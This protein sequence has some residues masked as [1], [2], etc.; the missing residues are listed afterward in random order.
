MIILILAQNGATQTH[1]GWSIG[2]QDVAAFKFRLCRPD[3]K[4]SGSIRKGA[5][6]AGP[7]NGKRNTHTHALAA[8]VRSGA[9]R[10]DGG[11]GAERFI[12]ERASFGAPIHVSEI[13]E[14]A[15]RRQAS[16]RANAPL[17][18]TRL[19]RSRAR[20]RRARTSLR[21]ATRR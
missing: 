13:N 2:E 9:A 12:G 19:A 3:Y 1:F 17:G 14:L 20:V 18:E 6:A 5:L 16:E 4:L 15:R 7:S 8:T 11:K 21:R 10:D